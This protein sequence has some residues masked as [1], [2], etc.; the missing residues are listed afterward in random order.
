MKICEKIYEEF[1]QT[2][3][4]I[5]QNLWQIHDKFVMNLSRNAPH[6]GDTTNWFVQ[7]CDKIITNLWQIIR[8]VTIKYVLDLSN[9]G[10]LNYDNI[11]INQVQKYPHISIEFFTNL[12][13]NYYK[14]VTN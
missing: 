9:I 8:I 3:L 12:L 7:I 10:L 5:H 13:Q 6:G 4:Q 1:V 2:F 11:L 14:F